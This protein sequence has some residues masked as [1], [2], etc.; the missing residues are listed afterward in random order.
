MYHTIT[1]TIQTAFIFHVTSIIPAPC[2]RRNNFCW[3]SSLLEHKISTMF[4]WFN[5]VYCFRICSGSMQ[6]HAVRRRSLRSETILEL[7]RPTRPDRILCWRSV[8]QFVTL[9]NFD[10]GCEG[11]SWGTPSH[12]H[13]L[14]RSEAASPCMMHGPE[15]GKPAGHA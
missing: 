3:Y 11:S 13:P 8:P 10:P 5:K 9:W 2:E 7:S 4:L 14:I 1:S 6:F 12:P 15:W